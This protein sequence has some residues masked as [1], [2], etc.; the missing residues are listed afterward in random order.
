LIELL[1]VVG[2]IAVLAGLLSPVLSRAKSRARLT[3]CGNNV[4]QIGL[5]SSLYVSDHAAFPVFAEYQ[6]GPAPSTFWPDR[7]QAYTRNSWTGDGIY[8][9]PSYPEANRP[10]VF[11]AST[12]SPPKGSYDMNGF[13]L[14]VLGTLGIGGQITGSMRTNWLPCAESKVVSSSQMVAYGDVIMGLDYSGSGYFGFTLYH[15]QRTAGKPEQV[16]ARTRKSRLLEARRHQGRFNVVFVD[17]HVESSKPDQLFAATDEGMS[18]W[19]NDHRPH[20]EEL[21]HWG[22]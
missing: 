2:I 8:R 13:G 3:Q 1:T 4:R 16:E 15:P 20:H 11:T 14:S 5:A 10:G 9:C 17:D 19:N 6:R 22:Q 21:R 12:W 18:Q 7:L